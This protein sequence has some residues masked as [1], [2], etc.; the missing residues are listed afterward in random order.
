MN[1]TVSPKLSKSSI[2]LKFDAKLTIK[3]EDEWSADII[4]P[5]KWSWEYKSIS[6]FTVTAPE[7]A[8][9]LTELLWSYLGGIMWWDDYYD[10][11]EY[12]YEGLYLDEISGDLDEN[13][14]ELVEVN[15]DMEVAE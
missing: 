14:D 15:A 1:W 6:D 11:E 10:D 5:F 7:S 2:D 9:D 12:D 8:Q 4:I 3:S 13:A